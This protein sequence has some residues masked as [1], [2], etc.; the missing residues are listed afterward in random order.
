MVLLEAWRS[1]DTKEGSSLSHFDSAFCPNKI[2]NILVWNCKG[3]MKLE[4]R[5]TVMDLVDWHDPIL[6]VIT[7]TRLFGARATEI[8]E[9]L[10]FEGAV[11][12]DTIGFARGIWM[13]WRSNRIQVDVLTTT[14]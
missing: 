12:A 2:M 10:P 5:K 14:E 11:V 7:E 4:F 9:G 1:R 6:M 3:A 8:I 13:L